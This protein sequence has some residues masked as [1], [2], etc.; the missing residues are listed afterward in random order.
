MREPSAVDLSR[1][2]ALLLAEVRCPIL[3]TPCA[4]SVLADALAAV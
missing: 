2:S 3:E 1:D 4:L